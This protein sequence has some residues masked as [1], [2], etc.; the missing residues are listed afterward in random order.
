MHYFIDGYNFLFQLYEEVD[1]LRQKRDEVIQILQEKLRH[2]KLN[3]TIV[4]DSHYAKGNFFPTRFDHLSLE[5]IYTPSGQTADSY[6]LE[7][8]S[9]KK[10]RNQETVITSDKHLTRLIQELGV[11]VESIESFIPWILKK[12]L[13]YHRKE[14]KHLSEESPREF[15][16]LLDAFEKRFKDSNF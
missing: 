6:I 16:R 4:F 14:H 12:E 5:I 1:P 2:L 7:A 11:K 10:I 8:L 13:R 3:I 9:W 15:E